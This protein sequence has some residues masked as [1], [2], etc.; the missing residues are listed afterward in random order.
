M[1]SFTALILLLVVAA[2]SGFGTSSALRLSGANGGSSFVV[3]QRPQQQTPV[4]PTTKTTSSQLQMGS[5]AKFGVF[6]PAVYAAKVVLGTNTLNKVRGKAISLHSQAIGDFC[7]WAGAYH[8]R[9]RLIKKAKVNGD[10][11]G[12]LV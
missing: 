3:S 10:I 11:L 7:V 2:A 1:K 8:L 4:R 6:S 12:F 9:V 5:M